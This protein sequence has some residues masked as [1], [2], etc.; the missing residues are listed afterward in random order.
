MRRGGEGILA[1]TFTKKF[2]GEMERRLAEV[3]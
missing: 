1:M 2:T 3:L